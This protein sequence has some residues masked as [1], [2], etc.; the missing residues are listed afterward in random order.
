MESKVCDFRFATKLEFKG[1]RKRTVC[2]DDNYI[3]PEILDGKSG[4]S[5]EVD[6]WSLGVI[7]YTLLIGKPPF[8][9]KDVNITHE[10]IKMNLYTFPSN[11]IISEAAKDLIGQI[12]VLDPSKRPSLDQ[13]LAHDFFHQGTFIPKLLPTST[14]SC[15]QSLS[16]IRQFIP[17]ANKDGIVNK[18]VKSI[19]LLDIPIKN[20]K[21]E[22]NSEIN[23]NLKGPNIWVTKWVDYTSKYGLGYSIYLI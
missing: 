20:K 15:T 18:P 5:Y 9:A 17:D 2:G 13:I 22:D 10:R 6:I 7:I 19:K 16:Y 11:A 21:L 1:E 3:A 4:H 8:K 14:L 12:L 23:V